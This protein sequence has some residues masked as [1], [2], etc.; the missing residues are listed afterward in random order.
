M[1]VIPFK[2]SRFD[3]DHDVSRSLSTSHL[4]APLEEKLKETAATPVTF[5]PKTIYYCSSSA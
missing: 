2:S 3:E 4:V 1:K 5:D